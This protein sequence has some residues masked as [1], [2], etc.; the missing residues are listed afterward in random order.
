MKACRAGLSPTFFAIINV[1]TLSGRALSSTV[2]S[3]S[4]SPQSTA[5]L[6]VSAPH[7]RRQS[8]RTCLRPGD[9]R[10]GSCERPIQSVGSLRSATDSC[11]ETV[12]EWQKLSA[13]SSAKGVRRAPHAAVGCRYVD[14]HPVNELPG[15]CAASRALFASP[16]T[17]H[18]PTSRARRNMASSTSAKHVTSHEAVCA[19]SSRARNL[20]HS[21]RVRQLRVREHSELLSFLHTKSN[22]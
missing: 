2:V 16:T 22:T 21:A 1:S 6:R 14:K 20:E 5:I 15:R 4:L 18:S 7:W 12:E 11:L 9:Q 13:W 3:P 19:A 8:L 10:R 17:L